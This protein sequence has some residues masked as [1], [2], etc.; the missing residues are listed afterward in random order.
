MTIHSATQLTTPQDLLAAVPFMVG[1]HPSN[2]LVIM[3][4]REDHISMAMRVDFPSAEAIEEIATNIYRHLSRASIDEVILV[5]YLPPAHFSDNLLT[6]ISDALR[7]LGVGIKEAIIV[8]NDRYRSTICEDQQCCPPDGNLIQPLSDSRITAE[9]VALGN[10]L[11]FLDLTAMRQSIAPRRDGA[12]G[13]KLQRAI[14]S[15]DAIDYDVTD[16]LAILASQREGANAVSDFVDRFKERG[17]PEDAQLV[18]LVLVRL[19]D[20]QVRDYAM[21]ISNPER[22]SA[23]RPTSNSHNVGDT[24]AVN[25]VQSIWNIGDAWRWLLTMAPPGYV[26]PVA[27]IFAAFCYEQGEGALAQRSLDRAFDDDSSY[28]MAKLL[29]RTFAA[30]WPPS[31][32]TQMRAEL[33]PKI[34]AALFAQA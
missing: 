21:G 3:A 33:H 23:D 24:H 22:Y 5:G 15:F 10:P 1:Y 26:A 2:S 31:A 12:E 25:E 13:K 18:A 17:A 14:Q 8:R 34:C 16:A 30:G 20:L 27:V 32:F 11:P 7:A 29:R 28:G 9:Q 19:L 6:G 4:M